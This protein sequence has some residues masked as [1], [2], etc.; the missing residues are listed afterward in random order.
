MKV[1]TKILHWGIGAA[2]TA[3]VLLL[4]AFFL[5][6]PFIN[7]ATMKAK[8]KTLVS[9]QIGGEVEFQRMDLSLFP[10][11]HVVMYH[12]SFSIPAAVSGTLESIRVYPRVFPLF[13]G[14]VLISK[15]QIQ[16]PDIKVILPDGTGKEKPESASHADVKE[17]LREALG[18]LQTIAPNLECQIDKG[19]FVLSKKSNPVLSLQNANARFTVSPGN[20]DIAVKAHSEPGGPVSL[21]FGISYDDDRVE[22]KDLYGTLGRSS[23]S[24]LSARLDLAK[25]PFIEVPSGKATISLDELYPLLSSIEGQGPLIR[26]I[27]SLKGVV[28]VSSMN[29]AGPISQPTRE[30]M[31]VTGDVANVIVDSILLPVPLTLGGR[32]S[33]DRDGIGVNDLAASAGRSSASGVSARFAWRKNQRIE[34]NAGRAVIALDQAYQWRS[35]FPGL[36]NLLKD[37]TGLK[38]T[39]KLSSINIAVP[40]SGPGT[41]KLSAAGRVDNIV[42]DSPLLPSPLSATGGFT[43]GRDDLEIG[44]LSASLGESS[45]SEVSARLAWKARPSLVIGSG[46]AVI[47]LG[48]VYQLRSQYSGLNEALK[49][50]KAL[51]GTVKFSSMHVTVSFPPDGALQIAAA[52]SMENISFDSSLL[53]GPGAISRG[54][55]NLEPGKLSFDDVHAAM[56]DA[57]ITL[58]GSLKDPLKSMEAADL[59]LKGTVGKES[60]QWAFKTFTLPP[61]LFVR[62]P[63]LLSDIHLIWQKSA[64][65]S[66]SGTLTVSDGPTIS[67]D[68]YRSPKELAVRKAMIKDQDTDATLMFRRQET[69]TELS[70]SGTLS[71]TTLTRI[72]VNLIFGKGKVEGKLRANIPADRP[73]NF[74]AE[75]VIDGDD[76]VIPWHLGP[77]LKVDRFMLHADKGVL[78][79]DSASLTWGS[80]SG[81]LKGNA[82]ASEEGFIL[83]MDLDSDGINVNEI[84]QTIATTSSENKGEEKN[85]D[86]ALPIG[87]QEERTSMLAIHGTFRVNSASVIYDRYTFK[88][89]KAIITLAPEGMD[90]AITE[91][92]VCGVAITGMFATSHGNVQLT[93]KPKAEQ[94]QLG[95]AI[96]CLAGERVKTTGTFNLSADIEMSGKSETLLSSLE[97]GIDFK[98]KDG[99]IYYAPVLARIFSLLSVTEIFRL[100]PPQLGGNGF[101][102]HSMAL[103][104]KLHKGKFMVEKAYIGGSSLHIIGQG[105]VDIAGNKADLVVLVSPFS[106]IDSFIRHIPLI[107][108]PLSKA[109]GG[110]VVSV[111][112]KVSGDLA[113]PNVTFLAPSAVGKRT[114][115]LMKNIVELPVEL[116]S[117]IMPPEKKGTK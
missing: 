33:L 92:T 78:T 52:G 57:S 45:I 5:A 99:K 103:Q 50:L 51:S 55:F 98:A 89:V 67:L 85:S 100:K 54:N 84:E 7:S 65:I 116:I 76:V 29:F 62:A 61:K 72:F 80:S 113:N 109:L 31:L 110:T 94:Q 36:E 25:T 10:S 11:P 17:T 108:K 13:Q 102:Y 117:P 101:P 40:L 74:A 79:V 24:G 20:I 41:W 90:A 19:A 75:G 70:F 37:V 47:A 1:R 15:V 93:F 104:G 95:S 12:P 4:I 71:E 73:L 22:V 115:D 68:L 16:A 46:K 106:G 6:T 83:D 96:S 34:V 66:L 23:V 30:R 26:E 59:S 97:G 82:R 39:V 53:P 63:V 44:G 42:I 88:P 3:F 21:S 60:M 9:Q 43:A 112:V 87:E 91:S 2:V 14:K 28:N 69:S 27:R 38:G 35:S 58:S 49:D 105:D 18:S 86:T 56:L 114:L 81:T 77:P 32:F 64:E 48:E 8:I 111:P 107:G